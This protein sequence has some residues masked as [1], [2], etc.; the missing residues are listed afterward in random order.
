MITHGWLPCAWQAV[1]YNSSEYYIIPY[2]MFK[3][4]CC[5]GSTKALMHFF[6]QNNRILTAQSNDIFYLHFNEKQYQHNASWTKSST[7]PH[8]GKNRHRRSHKMVVLKFWFSTRKLTST[9]TYL[10]LEFLSLFHLT[11]HICSVLGNLGP[12]N[13]KSL[14]SEWGT[15]TMK[16]KGKTNRNALCY[17]SD[18]NVSICKHPCLCFL[19][20]TSS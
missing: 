4:Q 15:G 9:P 12:L 8:T 16:N 19:T 2:L 6:V 7:P 13:P 11:M 5:S 1:I 10:S 17:L 3:F 18:L 14:V 20:Y